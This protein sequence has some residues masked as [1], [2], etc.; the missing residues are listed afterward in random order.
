MFQLII[1]ENLI[2]DNEK[3]SLQIK[4]NFYSQLKHKLKQCVTVHLFINR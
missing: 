3:F 4:A 1:I 2:H